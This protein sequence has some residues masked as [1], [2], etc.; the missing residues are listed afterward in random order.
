MAPE[1]VPGGGRSKDWSKAI[2]SLEDDHKA[3]ADQEAMEAWRE[4]T[5][6]FRN[7]DFNTEVRIGDKR[8]LYAD[9]HAIDQFIRR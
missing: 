3:R 5:R 9:W 4:F 1:S 2:R 6:K 7:G 8:Y